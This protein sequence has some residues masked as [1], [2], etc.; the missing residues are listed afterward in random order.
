MATTIVTKSGSGAPT[1]SDL[2]AGELAVDLTNGRLYT[3]NSGGTVLELGLNPNGNV[4]VTGSVT[5][6]GLT[7]DGSAVINQYL[8]L[9]TTDD[10]VN[11]WILYTGTTD[12]LEF[13]YNGSGNAE[14]VVDTAGNVGI[15]TS[16]PSSY[17]TSFNDLVVDGGTNSGV[18]VVSGTSGDGTIAFADGT[19]GNEAYRGYI[20]YTHAG[21][22]LKFGTAGAERM[23][24]D[25]SGNLLVGKTALNIG[26]VGQEFR[27]GGATYITASG[28]TVLGLNRLSSDGTVFEI[29]KDSAVV[30]SISVN[31]DKIIFGT[32]NAAI[33]IDQSSNILF[34]YNPA[35]PG[36]R[37]NAIDLGYASGRFKDLYLSG[38]VYL[39]GTGAANKLEDYEEGTFTPT[40]S[41]STT[42]GV[43][44]YSTR[45]GRYTKVGDS[46]SIN[47]A[48]QVTGTTTSAAGAV[49]ITGLPFN[50]GS[51]FPSFTVGWSQNITFADQLGA[52]GGG[53]Q[54]IL[55]NMSSGGSGANT[56]GS[57][58][59]STFYIF[60]SGTYH[61]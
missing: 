31:D 43:F 47:I 59:G 55:R 11:G 20:Q 48:M 12:K 46:V 41:G 17:N 49:L 61:L 44:T 14:V 39:G 21:D 13:N 34:P 6:D 29:R 19:T 35:T 4:N 18:T 36:A 42:A 16:T 56:Q 8:T 26:V 40:I 22:D 38:G 10:Q 5:A 57:A 32:A 54:I 33:A 25:S 58:L 28:D 15:G 50:V 53:T 51:A 27:A 52:Y 9:K 3:E 1:A 23:R 7:V 60:V 2:V 30:G 45:E 24:I 37:D